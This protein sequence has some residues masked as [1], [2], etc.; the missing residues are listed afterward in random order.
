VEHEDLEPDANAPLL[1][2]VEER[3]AL[4]R[5]RVVGDAVKK[6]TS[7]EETLGLIGAYG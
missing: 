1:D 5:S 4:R 3:A 7:V 6:D 2:G